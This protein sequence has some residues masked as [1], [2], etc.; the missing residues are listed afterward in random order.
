M[1]DGGGSGGEDG[2]RGREGAVV[3]EA[4]ESSAEGEVFSR[5]GCRADDIVLSAM[6]D[7]STRRLWLK[8]KNDAVTPTQLSNQTGS[9]SHVRGQKR[10][11]ASGVTTSRRHSINP[12]GR[13]PQRGRS[14]VTVEI[15]RR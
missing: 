1:E 5:F 4:M 8:C 12:A 14:R 3:E 2:G 15:V 10:S 11:M 9:N 13:R 6:D 7:G